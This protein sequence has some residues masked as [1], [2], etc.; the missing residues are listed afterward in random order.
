MTRPPS[1]FTLLELLVVLT[2]VAAA[3]GMVLPATV[4]SVDA[5]RDRAWQ[6]SLSNALASLPLKAFHSGQSLTLSADDARE[7]VVDLPDNVRL[8]LSAPL[9]YS[10]QGVASGG[11]VLALR[12]QQPARRWRIAEISGETLSDEPATTLSPGR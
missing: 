11:W 1:G 8:E 4:R 6:Q 3:V 5:A 2:L 9:R 10:A 7:L 12:D